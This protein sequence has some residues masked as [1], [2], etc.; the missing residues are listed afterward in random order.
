MEEENNGGDIKINELENKDTVEI[1]Q[2]RIELNKKKTFGKT[3]QEIKRRED[4]NNKIFKNKGMRLKR[5][6]DSN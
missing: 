4:R 5:G 1:N 2:Q 6:N 3:E